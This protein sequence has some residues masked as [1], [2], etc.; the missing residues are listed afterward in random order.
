MENNG[1]II[2]LVEMI[3]GW[4]LVIQKHFERINNNEIYYH[5]LSHKIQN[6]LINMLNNELKSAIVEKFKELPRIVEKL[7][8]FYV[9]L[10]CTPDVSYQ[11]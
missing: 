10:D 9:I 3:T 1:N 2:S 4:N 11:E 5:Y 7:K 8:Y 6:E